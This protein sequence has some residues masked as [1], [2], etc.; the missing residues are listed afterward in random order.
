LRI[1]GVF[2][3]FVEG[4]E[5]AELLRSVGKWRSGRVVECTVGRCGLGVRHGVLGGVGAGGARPG[6]ASRGE[7]CEECG[8]LAHAVEGGALAVFVCWRRVF[9]EA[10]EGFEVLGGFV[11][12]FEAGVGVALVHELPGLLDGFA[13]LGAADVLEEGCEGD[14]EVLGDLGEGYVGLE[15]GGEEAVQ[16]A[17]TRVDWCGLKKVVHTPLPPRGRFCAHGS[18]SSLWRKARMG[19]R[20]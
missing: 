9:G 8:Y 7:A 19:G 15:P 17:G 12:E 13:D 4:G 5:G 18:V 20:E 16:M 10:F 2:D 3:G 6:G 11:E 14:A 1:L